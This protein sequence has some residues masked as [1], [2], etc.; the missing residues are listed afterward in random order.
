MTL[1]LSFVK[2]WN[3][4]KTAAFRGVINAWITRMDTRQRKLDESRRWPDI[5]KIYLSAA[6]VAALQGNKV[7]RIWV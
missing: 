5:G 3:S 1:E 6:L 7:V 4:I 2:L